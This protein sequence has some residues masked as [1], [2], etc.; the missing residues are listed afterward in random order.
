MPELQPADAGLLLGCSR[1]AIAKQEARLIA[2]GQARRRGGRLVIEA[3]GLVRWWLANVKTGPVWERLLRI[4]RLLGPQP[5]GL[6][7]AAGGVEALEEQIGLL[8]LLCPEGQVDDETLATVLP[9]GSIRPL[10]EVA[11]DW[12]QRLERH[13]VSCAGE[14]EIEPTSG[15][16]LRAGEWV[17]VWELP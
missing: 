15:A 3:D 10:P 4:K 6:L 8:A 5:E 12:L 1:Q 17:R 14:L 11:A 7:L 16:V 13:R 9:D 2:A